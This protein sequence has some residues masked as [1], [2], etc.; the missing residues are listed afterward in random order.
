MW[1]V[2]NKP[3]GGWHTFDLHAGTTATE[4]GDWPTFDFLKLAP[5]QMRLP[6]LSLLSKGAHSTAVSHGF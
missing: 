4:G 3:S 1:R 2:C 6:H 5:P